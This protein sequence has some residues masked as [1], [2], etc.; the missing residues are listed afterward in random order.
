MVDEL[1]YLNFDA[2]GADLLYKIFNRRYQR[3]STIVTTN[4]LC[5]APHKRF[6]AERIVMHS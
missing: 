5:G 2:R 4:R 6:R 1:D 3:D